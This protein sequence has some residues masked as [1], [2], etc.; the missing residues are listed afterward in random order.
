M[1]RKWLASYILAFAPISHFRFGINDKPHTTGSSLS[2]T[3]LLQRHTLNNIWTIASA[4][5]LTSLPYLSLSSQ[6]SKW[7]FTVF[8]QQNLFCWQ[9]GKTV[10]KYHKAITMWP[11]YW[12]T[13]FFLYNH[14]LT[15]GQPWKTILYF[16]PTDGVTDAWGSSRGEFRL[17]T[18][19]VR[20]T[21]VP[22]VTTLPVGS[23]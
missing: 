23:Y 16:P 4:H 8:F 10:I 15:R 5:S 1:N 6:G 11:H 3:I 20:Q 18:C 7:D 17:V 12:F 22:V 9:W 2:L 21:S 19:E 13:F 14:I